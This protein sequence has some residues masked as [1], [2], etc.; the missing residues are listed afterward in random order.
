MPRTTYSKKEPSPILK[1][2]WS[3]PSKSCE[4]SPNMTNDF[5]LN[6]LPLIRM[7]VDRALDNLGGMAYDTYAELKEFQHQLEAMN[8]D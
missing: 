7:A 4:N 8:V 6:N 5:L 2:D 3:M 1:L